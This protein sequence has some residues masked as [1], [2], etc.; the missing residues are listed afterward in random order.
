MSRA[1]LYKLAKALEAI[2]LVVV[3]VGLTMSIQLGM[4]DDGLGSMKQEFNGLFIGGG[5]FAVGYI[6]ERVAGTR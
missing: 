4:A 3:L 5:L 2:G 6:L 1:H